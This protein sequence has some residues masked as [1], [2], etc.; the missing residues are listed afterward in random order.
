MPRIRKH[1]FESLGFVEE[2]PAQDL[3][4]RPPPIETTTPQGKKG[5]RRLLR[6]WVELSA[7]VS[8]FKRVNGKGHICK[9]C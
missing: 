4:L 8:D 6:V 9:L 2:G 7:W 5:R 1:I 3:T